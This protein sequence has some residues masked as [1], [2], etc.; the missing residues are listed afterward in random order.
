MS[1]D[2]NIRLIQELYGAFG[3]GDVAAILEQLSDDVQW[4]VNSRSRAAESV[5]WHEHLRGKG[6]VPKFFAALAA[7]AEFTRFEPQAFVATDDHVYCTVAWDA[8]YKPT[9]KKFSQLVLHRFTFERGRIVEW[10]G[11][12][13][14]ALTVEVTGAK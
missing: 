3:R 7:N 10:I 6:N 14:T 9:G 13:D 8:I 11:T 2:T 5:A 12:E 1:K 4:G